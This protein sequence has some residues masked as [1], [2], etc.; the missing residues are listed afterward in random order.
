MNAR[1][2]TGK[3]IA[4]KR[5][6]AFPTDTV[7]SLTQRC[8]GHLLALFYE[9]MSVLIRKE[10]L[11]V[12]DAVWKREPFK[13]AELDALCKIV[14]EMPPEEIKRRIKAVTFPDAPGAYVE[15]GGARFQYVSGSR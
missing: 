5:F 12:C 7:Y 3:I 6:P 1:V 11:P 15:L 9:M 14:P 13:R 10:Q 2:D 8:Y 4:V